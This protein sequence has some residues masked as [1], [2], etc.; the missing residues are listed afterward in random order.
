[1]RVKLNPRRPMA[2]WRDLFQK[3]ERSRAEGYSLEASC[4]RVGIAYSTY[5]EWKRRLAK[6][7][8][9]L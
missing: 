5:H 7:T 2:N 4:V 9:K 1:M 8:E 3:I 6:E